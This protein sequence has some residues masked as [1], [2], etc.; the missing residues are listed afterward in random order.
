MM[1]CL[2]SREG[3]REILAA[4]RINGGAEKRYAKWRRKS[5]QPRQRRPAQK[6]ETDKR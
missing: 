4:A 5:P 3:M 1:V 6:L 2:A